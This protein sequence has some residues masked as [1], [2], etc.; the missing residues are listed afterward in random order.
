VVPV[1]AILYNF[2][3]S[4]SPYSRLAAPRESAIRHSY[5]SME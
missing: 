5:L 3:I 1:Q 4:I 2:E